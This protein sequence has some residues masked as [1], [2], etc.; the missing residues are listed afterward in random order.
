MY[1][2]TM[3]GKLADGV[4][5]EQVQAELKAWEA[6]RSVPGYLS[7]HVMIADDGRTVI[8]VA[9][10]DTKEN[11]MALADDPAQDD[12]WQNHYAPMLDGD[13]QWIDGNWIH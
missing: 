8:N 12:W 1:G 7:S 13:P 4:T 2:S 10:F 3:I 11:Y 9:V 6:E 5:A